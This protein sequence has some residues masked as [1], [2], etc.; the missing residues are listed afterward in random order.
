[1]FRCII[2]DGA[3]ACEV[4]REILEAKVHGEPQQRAVFVCS[5]HEEAPTYSSMFRLD[6]S[7]PMLFFSVYSF[8]HDKRYFLSVVS[9]SSVE[10][11]FCGAHKLRRLYVYARGKSID[12]R[13]ASV[14]EEENEVGKGG[15]ATLHLAGTHET[16]RTTFCKAE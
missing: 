16:K 12:L 14:K 3:C 4:C 15:G 10:K 11:R 13:G 9:M 8:F 2:F 5:S 7:S 6:I 1:M